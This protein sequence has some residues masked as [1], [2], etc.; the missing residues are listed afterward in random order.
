MDEINEMEL[1]AQKALEELAEELQKA[2]DERDYGMINKIMN[3]LYLDYSEENAE[4]L[5]RYNEEC[6]IKAADLVKIKVN[7]PMLT[8]FVLFNRDEKFIK[9]LCDVSEEELELMS[10]MC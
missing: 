1:K 4:T 10:S 6:N 8:A 5:I 7:F 3:K 2:L 9:N